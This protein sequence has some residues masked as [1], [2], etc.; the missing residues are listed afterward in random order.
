MGHQ[1]ART[2]DDRDWHLET[3]CHMGQLHRSGEAGCAQRA[4]LY[5]IDCFVGDQGHIVAELVEVFAAGDRGA[6][7]ARDL[8]QTAVV[9]ASGWLLDPGQVVVL[10][11]FANFANGLLRRPEF[12]GVDHQIGLV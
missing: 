5:D 7:P 4:E 3:V 9:P 6:H 10:L 12:V 2:A 1:V 8:A 11:D